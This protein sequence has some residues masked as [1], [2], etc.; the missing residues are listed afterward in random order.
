M[1]KKGLKRGDNDMKLNKCEA[2]LP[3][4]RVEEARD[5]RTFVYLPTD[6]GI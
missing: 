3:G 2:Y 6:L 4:W 5:L 1:H